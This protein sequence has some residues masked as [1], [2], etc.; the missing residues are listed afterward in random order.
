[1]PA[2][3]RPERRSEEG[4]HVQIHDDSKME[5]GARREAER[6][7]LDGSGRAEPD[8]AVHATRS[9]A[10]TAFKSMA[11]NL[12]T[13]AIFAAACLAAVLIWDYYVTSPWT[14]DGRIRV[15]VA[16]IAPQVSGQIVEVRIADNQYVRKGDVLYVIDPFDY[17]AALG[18]AKAQLKIRAA[19]LQVKKVQAERR[20]SLSDLAVTVEDKQIFAGNAEQAEAAFDAAQVQVAQADINLQR[21]EVRSSVNGYVTNLLLRVG[22]YA[23][24]GT[25]NISVIDADSYWIDGYFEET[26]M[27]RICVGD[28]AE[29]RL[30]G[31]AMPILGRVET[32][33]RGISE[34]NA[35]P[36][37][38]GLPS[39]DPIYTW[40]RLAQRVPVRIAITGISPE[41]PLVAGM[42]ATVTI[43]LPE[44]TG[45]GKTFVRSLP[46]RAREVFAGP[47][48]RSGCVPGRHL[49]ESP[50]S[51]ISPPVSPE[52]LTPAQAVP[53][54]TPGMTTPPQTAKQ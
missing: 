22:D 44:G 11:K 26:K 20:Q 18:S 12:A 3:S 46:E 16:S 51:T 33:T 54:L 42:T 41:V 23:A 27:A 19:E 36:S 48:P 34:T 38:Q 45:D 28:V 1:M 8:E 14:R 47:A 15:Q 25:R 7:P 30:M 13:L 32:V 49:I 43:R 52:A 4:S 50:V 10:G 29:A 53:G 35:A 17:K 39:V 40:V 31:Y 2:D 9:R 24:A 37:T 21:T 5:G 6:P